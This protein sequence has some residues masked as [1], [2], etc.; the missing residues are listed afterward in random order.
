[1]AWWYASRREAE[2]ER[3]AP[4]TDPLGTWA[5]TPSQRATV[6][7]FWVVSALI[8]LQML[9]GVIVAHYGVEGN[10]GSFDTLNDFVRC[11]CRL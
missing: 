3:A 8:L 7:Y 6:K 9:L 11:G 5:A 1:M 10:R 2:E 4:A